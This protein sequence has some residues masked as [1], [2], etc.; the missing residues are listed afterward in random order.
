M[1]EFKALYKAFGIDAI[2]GLDDETF[3]SSDYTLSDKKRGTTD[4]IIDD[5]FELQLVSVQKDTWSEPKV[6]ER[7]Q[8]KRWAAGIN[9][10][11]TGMLAH[12]AQFDGLIKSHHLGIKPAAYFDTLSMARPIMPV[13]VGGSLKKVCSAFGIEAKKHADALINTKG[14]RWS[15]F[16]KAEKDALKVYAGEDISDTW[17]IFRKMLPF[18]PIEELR[19]I[20]LTVKMYAQPSVLVDEEGVRA[21]LTKEIQRKRDLVMG[22]GIHKGL[23]AMRQDGVQLD[24]YGKAK[25]L[26]GSKDKFADL[27]RAQGVEPPTKVSIK[28]SEKATEEAGIDT[29]VEV[30]AMSKQD[31]AF[32]DLLAHPKK[33]VRDLVE[34]RFAVASNILE[35]RCELLARRAG[36]LKGPQPVYLNYYGAKTG[37]WSGGDN[38]NWQNLSSKRREG[39]AELRASVHAPPGHVLI[40]ADLAQIEAR[41]TAWFAGQHNKV[42]AFRAYDAG[43]GPDV[44]RYTAAT[45]IYNKPIEKVTD[46]ERFIGKTCELALGFQAGWPRFAATLRIGAFGPPVDITDNLARDIHAAWRAGNPFIVAD[47]KTTQNMVRSAFMGAQRLEHKVVS[48]EGVKDKRSGKLTGWMHLPNGMAIRYDDLGVDEEKGN[49]TYVSEY[50]HNK[51]KP[52]TIVRTRLYGG[53][54]VENRIQALAR[55]VIAE[56]MLGIKDELKDK[57]RIAMS[58]HDEIVGVVPVRFAKKALAVFKE[59]MSQSPAWAPDL[60]IAVDAHASPRYDK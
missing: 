8:F 51:L 25:K 14:K 26:L 49:V 42:E 12:H 53:I 24:D 28:Q 11:R 2:Y 31:Q 17:A 57:V 19:L 20:D 56:H 46:S 35:N 7:A 44:Y 23:P 10:A 55:C 38:A 34:A 50:R 39:G 6:M 58:T 9:W 59:V 29:V 22:L 32:K 27:L 33:K 41:F 60:P 3:W 1:S 15:E 47:W 48:Y 36:I 21:V 52:P 54:E 45:V 13:A 5:R 37:R 4:Y 40:I 16:T 30:L 18:F 43:E